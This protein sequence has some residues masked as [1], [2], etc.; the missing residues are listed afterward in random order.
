G[1]SNIHAAR[2]PRVHP[3]TPC[4]RPLLSRA[5]RAILIS[6]GAVFSSP[7]M[8]GTPFDRL[9]E[10]ARSLPSEAGMQLVINTFAAALRRQGDR[11]LIR[12]GERELAVS[13]HKVQSIL[14]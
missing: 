3:P 9:T 6:Q 4:N 5:G 1:P 12:A 11:F 8:V 14:V 10:S 13:A 2:E 7:T